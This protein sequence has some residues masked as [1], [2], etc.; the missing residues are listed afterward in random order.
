MFRDS[1]DGIEEYT[2]SVIGFINKCIDDVVPTVTL[3]TY[4]NQKPLITGNILTELKTRAAAFKERDS[5]PEAYKK[6][7]YALRRTIKQA[8]HQYRTKIELYYTGSDARR[9]WQG[10]Q[11]ITDYNGMHS[12]KLPSD[13]RLPDE[14]N[15]FYTHVKHA[16]KH[17]TCSSML[18]RVVPCNFT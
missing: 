10:L 9:M 6:S 1:S 3:H 2:T 17:F 5:N 4:P 14:L 16:F 8:K 11:T 18:S 7:Q 15:Y 12:R 13:T